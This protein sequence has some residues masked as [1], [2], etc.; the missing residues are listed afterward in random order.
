[1]ARNDTADLIA[2]VKRFESIPTSQQTFTD[3]DILDFLEV[4]FQSAIQPL[5]ISVREEFFVERKTH[6]LDST[7]TLKIPPNT[8]GNRLRDVYYLDGSN[9]IWS[10]V[11]RLS[12]EQLSARAPTG[13]GA[14][15][16]NQVG[17]YLENN[18]VK[19]VPQENS[20]GRTVQLSILRRP[21]YLCLPS[22]AGFITAIV[23][24]FVTLN[25]V[26]STWTINTRLDGVSGE[27]YYGYT[28]EDF[29]PTFVSG[30]TLQLPPAIVANLRVNDWIVPHGLAPFCQYV[31]TETYILLVQGAA[32]RCLEALGDRQG[33]A[34]A[35]EK[36]KKMEQDLY[37]LINPRV[38]G[39]AKRVINTNSVMTS[40]RVRT[41]NWW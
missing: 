23:G 6:T 20:A 38:D 17:F 28:D 14:Q 3:R 8:I 27:A 13:Y 18:Y 41:Y 7:A 12:P 31:P 19:F 29:S 15:W 39:E 11:P 21:A 30:F 25:N 34:N 37:T 5:V 10:N 2:R 9:Q 1:M 16:F 4:E 40:S 36:Y 26:P 33:W 22:D 24:D 32:M 35:A